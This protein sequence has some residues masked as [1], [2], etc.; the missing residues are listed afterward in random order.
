MFARRRIVIMFMTLA[1]LAA[2]PAKAAD[3]GP[4]PKTNKPRTQHDLGP[5]QSTENLQP[6][7]IGQPRPEKFERD[8]YFYKYETSLSVNAGPFVLVPTNGDSSSFNSS[9]GFDYLWWSPTFFHWETGVETIP[10]GG[11]VWTTAR[12]NRTSTERFR[13]FTSIGAGVNIFPSDGLATFLK[14][15]R[16]LVR[17]AA[18][19]EIGLG[20]RHSFRVE[21]YSSSTLD[22]SVTLGLNFGYSFGL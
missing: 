14:F 7:D 3:I 9:I 4:D 20:G 11:R 12:W 15:A 16:Y 19:A 10:A 8:T 6:L 18:G 2:A 22:A 1:T 21:F 5:G 17:G 13:P